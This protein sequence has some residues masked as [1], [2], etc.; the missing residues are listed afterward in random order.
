MLKLRSLDGSDDVTRRSKTQQGSR[1]TLQCHGI[2]VATLLIRAPKSVP[3]GPRPRDHSPRIVTPSGD[4]ISTPR[5][6]RDPVSSCPPSCLDRS[7]REYPKEGKPKHWHLRGAKYRVSSVAGWPRIL[8]KAFGRRHVPNFV[9][10][11]PGANCTRARHDAGKWDARVRGNS[12][13]RPLPFPGLGTKSGHDD[14]ARMCRLRPC[15]R[16]CGVLLRLGGFLVE[17]WNVSV[18][19]PLVHKTPRLVG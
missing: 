15:G 16:H 8:H 19:L 5:S 2:D 13:T 4:D 3:V 11:S 10:P 9:S 14:A 6:G 7:P 1:L 18:H 17:T 12:G